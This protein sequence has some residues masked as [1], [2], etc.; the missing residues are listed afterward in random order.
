MMR[1]YDATSLHQILLLAFEKIKGLI[2][3]C[4]VY[5]CYQTK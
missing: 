3:A 1:T 4:I 5:V 2:Y